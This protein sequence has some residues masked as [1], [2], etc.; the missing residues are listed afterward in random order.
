MRNESQLEIETAWAFDIWN[1][2]CQMPS[3]Y[4]IV[5]TAYR[6]N[7]HLIKGALEAIKAT[8]LGEDDG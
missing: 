7:A 3:G 1:F 2:V 6:E 8:Y 4:D 5:L